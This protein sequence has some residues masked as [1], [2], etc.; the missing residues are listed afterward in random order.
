MAGLLE[1]VSAINAEALARKEGSEQVG[2]KAGVAPLTSIPAAV[3]EAKAETCA[4]LLERLGCVSV[5]GVLSQARCRS[6]L[7][8]VNAENERA[9]QEVL[10]GTTSFDSRFGGVN[11]RG[12]TASPFGRRQDLFLPVA[13]P[14]V[15]DAISE[16]ASNLAAFITALSGGDAMFHEISSIVAAPGSPR[17][18]VHADTIVLPCPQFPDASMEPLYTFFVA[19][20]DVEE[21]MGHTQFLPGTHTAGTHELWNA[22]GKSERLKALFISAQ[23]AQQSALRAGDVALFDSRVLHCGCANTSDKQRVL[24]YFTL[25]RSQRWA[26]PGGLHG[27]N[28]VREEDRWRW[29]LRDFGVKA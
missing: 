15:R 25:S 10:A 21:G 27:S 29:Q 1:T 3:A 20:Q 14:E 6:L 16:I 24:F 8:F 17:Q 4:R 22:A 11:C 9:Q 2:S 23:P 28:S 12:L 7:A 26:L 13:A 5:T 19:L 18:C